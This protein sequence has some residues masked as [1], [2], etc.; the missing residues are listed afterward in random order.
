MK[1]I[2]L[3]AERSAYERLLQDLAETKEPF[4]LER[5]GKPLGAFIP[6]EQY[7]KFVKWLESR[8]TRSPDVVGD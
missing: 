3:H 7:V 6:Y 8:P 1:I 4:I 5:D 2:Q